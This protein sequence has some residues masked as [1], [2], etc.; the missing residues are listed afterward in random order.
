MIKTHWKLLIF[1]S[2]LVLLP[3]LAGII[4]WDMLPQ[5]IPSHWNVVRKVYLL[6][7]HLANRLFSGW[8]FLQSLSPKVLRLP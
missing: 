1:T 3:M 4:I 6:A 5:Q 2:I 8:L 7:T